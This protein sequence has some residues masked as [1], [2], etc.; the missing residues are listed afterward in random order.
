MSKA[1][2]DPNK[3]MVEDLFSAKEDRRQRLARLPLEEKIKIV[4]KL[5]A[6]VSAAMN[7]ERLIFESFLKTCPNFAN[8]PIEEWDVVEDWYPQRGLEPPPPPFNK[9]P[10]VIAHT[11]SGKSDR[12]RT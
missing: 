9:R 6:G 1:P 2:F 4:K 12:S 5:Q 8:E 11:A 7:N 3:F 10:D